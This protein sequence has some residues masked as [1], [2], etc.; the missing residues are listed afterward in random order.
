MFFEGVPVCRGKR[1]L[2][3][4]GSEHG[5]ERARLE[6]AHQWLRHGIAQ[7][8]QERSML[9]RTRM[10]VVVSVPQGVAIMGEGAVERVAQECER[11][12]RPAQIRCQIAVEMPAE[13]I[14]LVERR[15]L[16]T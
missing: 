9:E 6:I 15:T 4:D 3:R 7:K 5:A 1:R 11:G 14:V 8:T 2:Q 16:C 12:E 13:Q 10:V